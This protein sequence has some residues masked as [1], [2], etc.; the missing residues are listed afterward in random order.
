M[1]SSE[2][3]LHA[4][5]TRTQV[6]HTLRQASGRTGGDFGFLVRVAER[7]S[8][9]Q[10]GVKAANSSAA[11]VFQF[12]EQTW[13]QMVKNHGAKYGMATQANAIKAVGGR[14][15]VPDADQ[16]QAILARRNDPRLATQMAT[17]LASDNRKFLEK[18]LGRAATQGE[19]YAA[20]AFGLSGALRMIQAREAAPDRPA[21]QVLP[22]AAKAN[23]G[24]FYDRTTQQPRSTDQ[25]M[26]RLDG[27]VANKVADAGPGLLG[28]QSTAALLA[29][30]Q[31]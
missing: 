4:A 3:A 31:A 15:E 30:Q 14:Y 19:V 9:F 7:E 2:T 25:I 6:Q 12:T 29:L 20:H 28:D 11:G 26:A 21:D 18:R 23:P 17:E 27:I 16:R 8:R 1:I 24:I 22:A 5:A 13:L 10:S